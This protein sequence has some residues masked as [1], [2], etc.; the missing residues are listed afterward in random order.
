MIGKCT[1]ERRNV[2]R[3]WIAAGRAPKNEEEFIRPAGAEEEKK[4]QEEDDSKEQKCKRKRKMGKGSTA[5][6]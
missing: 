2:G 3:V 6:A 5:I 4:L 1:E